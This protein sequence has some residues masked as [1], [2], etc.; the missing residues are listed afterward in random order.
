MLDM[1]VFVWRNNY[2]QYVVYDSGLEY[3]AIEILIDQTESGSLRQW[4][5]QAHNALYF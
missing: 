1:D 2:L 5:D 3:L 4:W